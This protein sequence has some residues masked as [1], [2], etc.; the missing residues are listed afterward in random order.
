ME[1]GTVI[2]EA[3]IAWNKWLSAWNQYMDDCHVKRMK[4]FVH[5]V[6]EGDDGSSEYE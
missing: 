1:S 6:D 2:A 5:N 3:L 4:K